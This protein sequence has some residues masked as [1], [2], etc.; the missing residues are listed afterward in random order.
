MIPAIRAWVENAG[1]DG[2]HDFFEPFAGGGI[3]SLS[4]AFENLASDIL[5]VELDDEVAAV[6]KTILSGDRQWL[7]DRILSFEMSRSNATEVLEKKNKATRDI[8]FS[9]ILKNRIY[10][11]G[12]ITKGSGLM[13]NGENGKGLTS[14]WYPETLARRISKVAEVEHKLR[15]T[16]GD[17]FTQIEK[18]L[19]KPSLFTFIDPPYLKAGR[20]LYT[21][22]EIDH[23]RLF[24][25]ASKI[26]GRFMM[27]YD[28]QP[29]LRTLC[30]KYGLPY[31]LIPMKTT[32]HIKKHELIICDSFEWLFP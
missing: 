8:A 32:H 25:L 23:E 28:D 11:G 15:F 7:I 20:R 9:T 21:H 18:I 10:H 17:A 4:V 26:R 24:A 30:K 14:R 29:A 12:I 31:R 19:D 1:G 3:V 6:W 16:H 22:F 13:K 27:T 2:K 5:M